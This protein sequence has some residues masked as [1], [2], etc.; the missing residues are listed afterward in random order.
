MSLL[1][2]ASILLTP[3]GYSVGS[4]NAIKPTDGDGDMDFTRASTATRVDGNGDI[5]DSQGNNVPRINYEDGC[6]HILAEPSSTNRLPYSEDFTQWTVDSK[7]ELESGFS[8]PDGGTN[9]YKL[10]SKNLGGGEYKVRDIGTGSSGTLS[11]YAKKGEVLRITVRE[12]INSTW[13]NTVFNLN[14]GVVDDVSNS[15]YVTASMTDMGDGWYKCVSQYSSLRTN[16]YVQIMLGTNSGA[17]SGA[18]YTNHPLNDGLYLFGAQFETLLY[19]TS[20]IPTNGSAV[21]RS[22]EA[23]E[24]SGSITSINSTEG[25]FFIESSILVT[26]NAFRYITLSDGTTSNQLSII[27][28]NTGSTITG[29][30]MVGGVQQARWD[31]GITNEL[32]FKKFAIAWGSNE[33]I[34]YIDGVKQTPFYTSATLPSA[35]TFTEFS[36]HRGDGNEPFY[37]KIRS[38]AVF[39]EKLTETQLQQLTS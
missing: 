8:S 29:R 23:F 34:L 30:L 1:D 3:T 22:Q 26:N 32:Q 14:T 18:H 31:K 20:Y 21:T 6:G 17:G 25:T 13:G 39:K 36:L 27:Y 37:G 15:T 10:K 28:R 11:F 16:N 7:V 9:A 12:N 38:A 5:S 35:D 2:K 19:S 24:N 33:V 4:L